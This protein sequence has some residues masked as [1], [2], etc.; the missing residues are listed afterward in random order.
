MHDNKTYN[1]TQI[2]YTIPLIC[3]CCILINF[4]L[5]TKPTGHQNTTRIKD[6]AGREQ[7]RRASLASVLALLHGSWCNT[8]SLLSFHDT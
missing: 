6:R 4:A 1:N 2:N 7:V 8:N 5:V 3:G